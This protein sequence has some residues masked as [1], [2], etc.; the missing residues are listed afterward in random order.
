V[1]RYCQY[2]NNNNYQQHQ[3]IEGIEFVFNISLPPS[4]SYAFFIY[5]M[6][7]SYYVKVRIEEKKKK[8]K[9]KIGRVPIEK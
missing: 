7:V 5:Y 1:R 2:K 8:K 9:I 6:D 3:R 4:L